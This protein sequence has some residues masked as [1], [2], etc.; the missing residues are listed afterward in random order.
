MAEE[1][2][3]GTSVTMATQALGP[4][5]RVVGRNTEGLVERDTRGLLRGRDEAAARAATQRPGVHRAAPNGTAHRTAT[6]SRREL[7]RAL[8]LL[9]RERVGPRGSRERNCCLWAAA[10]PRQSRRPCRTV[11]MIGAL[12]AFF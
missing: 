5:G 2:V 8:S 3:T 7:R 12:L 11:G 4:R 9:E 10:R 6:D 1:A